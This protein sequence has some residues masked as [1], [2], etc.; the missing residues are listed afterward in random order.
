L[1]DFI[2]YTTIILNNGRYQ[3]RIVIEV[4]T[5]IGWEGEAL[6]YA[7]GDVRAMYVFINGVWC[8]ISWSI[9]G[10]PGSNYVVDADG[11]TKIQV[12]EST[13]EDII[14]FDT[15]DTQGGTAGERVT[16]DYLGMYVASGLK[17]GFEGRTGDTYW[18][19]N[20]TTPYL[21]GY[22]DGVKRVEF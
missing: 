11:D 15:G 8:N 2:D 4:P 6:V 19:Y 17:L 9:S 13:D 12:E 16:I 22:I 18:R 20:S 10:A 1:L 3:F 7:A 14:R 21:E 5:W